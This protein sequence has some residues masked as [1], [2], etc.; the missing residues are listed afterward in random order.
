MKSLLFGSVA[1]AALCTSA[2]AAAQ[3]THTLAEDAA[4]FGARERVVAAQLS[5]EGSSVIYLTP[6]KGPSTAAV[7]SNLETGKSQVFV[8][9]DG[10]PQS[11]R[12]C[13]YS[14]NNRVVCR[15]TATIDQTGVLT[16]YSRLIAMDS[17]GANAK[18]LGQ[19][20]RYT[21]AAIRQFDASILDWRNAADGSVLMEREYVPEAGKIG[22]NI[23]DKREGLGVD[24]VDT[25]TLRT[26]PV[27]LPNPRASDYLTDGRGH[28]RIMAVEE[29]SHGM[30]T[31]RTKY[32]YRKAGSRDWKDLVDYQK[33][34]YEP[35]GI[36]ADLDSLYA[37]KKRDGRYALYRIK[38]DGSLAETLIADNPRVDIDD[39]VRVGDGLKVIGYTYEADKPEV[40]YFDPEF[41]AL[42]ASLSRALPNLPIVEFV[43]ATADGNKLL[44]FAG[45]DRDPGRYYV[46][47]RTKKTLNEAMLAR[48][49]LEHYTLA[50]SKPVMI[51]AA[52]GMQI[53]AY[54]TLPPGRNPKSLPAVVLPHGGPSSRDSW[55]F[56][57]LSQFLAARGYAVIQPEYRGS[58]GFGE[59][60]QNDNGFRNWRTAMS[61]IASSARWLSSQGIADFNRIAIFGWSYGG[62]A[63]L[64]EAETDPVLYKAVIA[65]APVTDLQMLKDDARDYTNHEVVEKFVGS[66]AYVTEGSPL[67]NAAAIRVPV[68]LAH[69]DM[70]TNVAFRHSQKMYEALQSA[71]KQV[72]FLSFKGLDHQLQ[73]SGALT[74]VFTKMGELLDR[75]IGH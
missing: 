31:G 5:P 41:R 9:S 2:A 18:L 13:D 74:Q 54:L 8:S 57:T 10:A 60:W 33:D 16:G 55:G 17:D 6:A 22:T 30:L 23:V 1:M 62:Y 66:G 56:D 71:G 53:P 38:L 67:R 34:Q 32:Y 51:P 3:T 48:P 49:E 44:I 68:L 42:A 27:E 50:D 36:D 12:W 21:D 40:V 63:A 19:A 70:D 11:L 69:G 47:D 52:D 64:Q 24:L 37:L 58:A 4:A 35:L 72:E 73:D 59:K 39:I 25:R 20:D 29:E 7:I 26:T 65:V 46:F 15:F 45:S 61:D 28:V 43:D 75:T 14:S